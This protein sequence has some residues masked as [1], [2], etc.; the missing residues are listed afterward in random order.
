MFTNKMNQSILWG[1]KEKYR[2]LLIV[3]NQPKSL[4]ETLVGHA[5]KDLK[6]L[7]PIL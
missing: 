1:G 3:F 2:K 6:E 4:K 7:G 5:I